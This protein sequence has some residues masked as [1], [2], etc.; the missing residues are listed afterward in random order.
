MTLVNP[1][2]GGTTLS[3]NVILMPRWLQV[4]PSPDLVVIWF[5][6]NDWDTDVR[7]AAVQA[8]P[9]PWPLIASDG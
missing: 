1:A 7:G 4:A 8:V 2:I 6:G 3:Q 9:A 5:G